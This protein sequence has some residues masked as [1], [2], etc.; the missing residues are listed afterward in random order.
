M[1]VVMALVVLN[2]VLDFVLDRV[3]AV[4]H[5]MPLRWKATGTMLRR[6]DFRK[7]N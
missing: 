3:D 1:T 5:K 7:G 2:L 4:A 6:A